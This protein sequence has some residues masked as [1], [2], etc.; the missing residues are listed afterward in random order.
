MIQWNEDTGKY[1]AFCDCCAE[2]SDEYE[3]FNGCRSGLKESGWKTGYD[4]K[5]NAVVHF[6]PECRED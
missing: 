3:T 4:P 2:T 5:E 1:R 6:C